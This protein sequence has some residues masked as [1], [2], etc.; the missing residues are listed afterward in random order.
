MLPSGMERLFE[1]RRQEYHVVAV[2]DDGVR[3]ATKGA[4]QAPDLHAVY[5]IELQRGD[6][7]SS[8]SCCTVLAMLDS[9]PLVM[10]R[11]ADDVCTL[12]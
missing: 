9:T 7:A 3:R 2:E 1:S 8:S 4:L 10:T 12:L 11:R 5:R 6:G